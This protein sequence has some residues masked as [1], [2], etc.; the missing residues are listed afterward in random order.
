MYVLFEQREQGKQGSS[1]IDGAWDRFY[2]DLDR[3]LSPGAVSPGEP[4]APGGAAALG[5]PADEADAESGDD[6]VVEFGAA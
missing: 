2:R 3:I 5:E 4:S 6:T 1:F